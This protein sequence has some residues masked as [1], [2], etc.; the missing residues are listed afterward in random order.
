[1]DV[2]RVGET[3]SDDFIDRVKEEF[4]RDRSY[5]VSGDVERDFLDAVRKVF[6][7]HECPDCQYSPAKGHRS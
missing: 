3:G 1:M 2:D 6:V 5:L 4:Y 7:Q